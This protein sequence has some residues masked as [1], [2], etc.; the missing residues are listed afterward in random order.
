MIFFTLP[1][2][3]FSHCIVSCCI[4]NV[5]LVIK[6]YFVNAQQL[7]SLQDADHSIPQTRGSRNRTCKMRFTNKWL[8]SFCPK[9]LCFKSL[10]LSSYYVYYVAH[11]MIWNGYEKMATTKSVNTSTM[12]ESQLNL[13]KSCS[14]FF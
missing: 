12:S 6:K 9:F 10:V 14:G 2:V 11:G 3:K 7:G 4:D 5:Y 1:S 8:T 13:F